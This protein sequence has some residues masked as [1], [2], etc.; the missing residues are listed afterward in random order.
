MKQS[1]VFLYGKHALIEALGAAPQAV[2]RV[3]LAPSAKNDREIQSLVS[4]SGVPVAPLA[5]GQARAD[6]ERGTP[7]QG[8]IAQISLANLLIPYRRFMDSLMP[9]QKTVLVVLDSIQDPHN[10]GAIIRTGAAF[11][12]TA[13]LMP[14]SGQAPVTG[15]V[16]KASAGMAF[17]I[18]LVTIP[19]VADAL[20]ALKARGFAIYGLAGEEKY[21]VGE[22]VFAGPSVLVF[23]NEGSGL[24]TV[25]RM[26][27]DRLLSIPLHPRSESLNVAAAAAVALAAWS[28]KHPE[29][30][31]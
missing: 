7:H 14:E 2:V 21:V 22:E 25:T 3:F 17:R 8:V 10:V 4:R 19:N 24:R 31:Q 1:K 20:I 30:L 28:N 6:M 27:C 16:I 15:A 23:G 29:A 26:Q 11:G 13:V 12:A 9:T 18:P 5:M